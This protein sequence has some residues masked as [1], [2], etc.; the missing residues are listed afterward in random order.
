[1]TELESKVI[2]QNFA[3]ITTSLLLLQLFILA[4]SK[5]IIIIQ[6]D[7]DDEP[8]ELLTDAQESAL[9]GLKASSTNLS[10]SLDWLSTAGG[11]GGDDIVNAV[12]TDWHSSGECAEWDLGVRSET[13]SIWLLDMGHRPRWW[14][15]K[16]CCN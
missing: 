11:S 8:S 2:H 16:Y 13:K 12:A 14:F 7:S 1:M 9:A 3:I 10:L 4:T 6:S 5:N 15:F